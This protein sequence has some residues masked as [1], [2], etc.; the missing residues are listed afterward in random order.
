VA[1]ARLELGLKLGLK[2]MV[3]KVNPENTESEP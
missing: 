1:L 3:R 2:L